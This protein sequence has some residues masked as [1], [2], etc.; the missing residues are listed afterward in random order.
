MTKIYF[1][2]FPEGVP[3]R[4][5]YQHLIVCLGE[6]FKE[7]GTDFY[8]N[9]NYWKNSLDENDYLFKHNPEITPD[10]C[11]IVIVNSTGLA[12][13]ESLPE[14]LFKRDRKYI[15]VYMDDSDGNVTHSWNPEFRQFDFIFKTHFNSKCKYP[16]N[17]YPWAFGISQR[18]LRATIEQVIPQ[19][20]LKKVLVNFRCEHSVRKMAFDEFISSIQDILAIDNTIEKFE[21]PPVDSYDYLEFCQTGR[22]HYPSYYKRLTE[23]FACACFGGFFIPNFPVNQVNNVRLY[24]RIPNKL[25]SLLNNLYKRPLSYTRRVIQWDSWR[26]WESLAAGCLTFQLDFEKYG[27]KLPVMPKNYY[28]YIGVDLENVEKSKKMIVDNYDDLIKISEN[29]KKWALENYSPVATS[30]R[31][32]DIVNKR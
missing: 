6:G 14:N 21:S 7:L 19:Q 8:S 2:C 17:I 24:H 9:L 12:Y 22:R 3:E 1:Y 13:G 4:A 27:F 28:H 18:I 25:N 16:S 20:R 23:S 5:A 31:F 29:G 10:D 32:L 26:L 30:R 11:T 15:T